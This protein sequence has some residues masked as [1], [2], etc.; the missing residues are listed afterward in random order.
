[1]KNN[2]TIIITALTLLLIV[3]GTTRFVNAN[4]PAINLPPGQVTMK[5]IYP[6]TDS[7]DHITL[8]N[9]PAGYHVTNGVYLAWCADKHHSILVN[10]EYNA[11][12]YSSYDLSN[13]LP[14]P[15]WDKVNYI[16]NH[17]QGTIKDVQEAIW[18]FV[19]GGLT[20]STATGQAIVNDANTNGTGFVPIPGQILAVIV[21]I[22]V[23]VQTQLIEV[24]APLENLTPEY[25]LGPILGVVTFLAALGVFKFKHAIPKLHF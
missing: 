8:S 23:E 18:Y 1:M 21:W 11:T 2:R 5:M 24:R 20:P 12:L 16:L 3:L 19:N 7:Y 4:G 14:D 13:P 6:A 9:V 17:K 22:R 10:V 25:P 15:D